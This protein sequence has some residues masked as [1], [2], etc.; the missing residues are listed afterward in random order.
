MQTDIAACVPTSAPR[1]ESETLNKVNGEVRQRKLKR[2]RTPPFTNLLL[3]ETALQLI[4]EQLRCIW[5]QARTRKE[6]F[7]VLNLFSLQSQPTLKQ[8]NSRLQPS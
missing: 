6:A 4:A 8:Y 2:K 1:E 5:E 7:F 3:K